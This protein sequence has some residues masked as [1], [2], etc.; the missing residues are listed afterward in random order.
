MLLVQVWEA[1]FVPG[2][3]G[4]PFENSGPAMSL[5]SLEPAGHEAL[6]DP[7]SRADPL[8]IMG[9]KPQA[10]LADGNTDPKSHRL[11]LFLG[12]QAI[13]VAVVLNMFRNSGVLDIALSY[14]EAYNPFRVPCGWLPEAEYALLSDRIVRPYGVFTGYGKWT[15]SGCRIACMGAAGTPSPKPLAAVPHAVQCTSGGA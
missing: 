7:C 11:L 10:G 9:K 12:M 5:R 13:A 8:A 1:A 2:Q 14:G 3:S 4:L 6:G 15:P